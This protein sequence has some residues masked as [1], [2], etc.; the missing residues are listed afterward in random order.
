VTQLDWSRVKELFGAALELPPGERDAWLAHACGD[1]EHLRAELKSLVA[2]YESEQNVTKATQPNA[3]ALDEL[4][5]G[6]RIGPYQIIRRIGI[7]G[8]GAVYLA[9]R[10]D[11]TFRKSVAIKVVQASIGTE[12]ILER[13]R[14]ERQIL[15]TL[16]HPNIAKL[17]DG[18][19]TGEGLPF[20]A[21][22]FIEGV[23]IDDYSAQHRLSVNDRVR[24]FCQVCSAV[25]Y[26]HQNL[27][28][29]RDLK[30][31]NILVTAEGVP[32]LLDFGIAK[33][34]K[35]DVLAD[36]T[37]AESRPLTPAY[38]SPEQVR[39][40]PV[41]TASDVYSLGVI[42]YELLTSH[43]PCRPKTDSPQEAMIAIC[44]QQPDPPSAV[45]G[46]PSDAEV[47]AAV[48]AAAIAGERGTSPE[49]LRRHLKGDLDNITLKALRKEPHRRYA[50]VGQFAD[51]L[52]RYL[53]GLP[54]SA[55]RDTWTYRAGK[56]VRRH[57]LFV[58]AA[59]LVAISLA[60]G[61]L[62]ALSQARIAERERANAQRQFNDVRRLATSFLFEF[63][64]AIR[65]LRGSTPARK[66]LVQRALEYL[67]RLESESHGNL[68]LE[69][70]LASAYIKVGDVQGNPY[71]S[72]LGDNKGAVWSYNQAL[73]I[74]RTLVQ[75]NARDPAAQLDLARSLKSLGQVLPSNGSP[76]EGLSDLR[77]ACE[78]FARLSA[79]DAGNSA[80]EGELANC[81]QVRGDLQGH[82]GLPNM[83]D[84]VSALRSYH[85]ALAIY[86]RQ[87]SANPKNRDARYGE[88]MLRV[89]IGDLA[90]SHGDLK[91]GMSEYHRA[92]DSLGELSAADPANAEALRLVALGY[93]KIG[94]AQEE[95][96]DTRNALRSYERA[97]SINEVLLRSDPG[98]AQ[99]A[100]ALAITL[101][102]SGDL[103]SR[104]GDTASALSNYEKVLNI[105]NQ[106]S[107]EQPGNVL[108]QGRRTEQLL[109][110][111]DI[112]QRRGNKP[113]A[114]QKTAEAQAIT[115]RLAS[116]EDATADDLYA[117]ALTFLDCTPEEMRDP[118]TAVEYA[119]RAVEKS[120]RDPEILELLGRAYYEEGDRPHAIVA[121][122]QALR[123][124]PADGS[125]SAARRRINAQL[126]KFRAAGKQR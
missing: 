95:S 9:V 39:G 90:L 64:G 83:D 63:D 94:A 47:P 82:S 45:I 124:L 92:L 74:S 116:R 4:A 66:L 72:N 75:A 37:R 49:K 32:K 96:G 122:E 28:V 44:E 110:I 68:A 30:P 88:A 26:V 48:T 38:A 85:Q 125:G 14:H 40:E 50:S 11:D 76:T 22:D 81:Y 53:E 104:M 89:K 17:L 31:S 3:A 23:R 41:T 56:F 60:A 27:V 69:S 10:A 105:L 84:A 114:R 70:E 65:N 35:P 93:R 55:H 118:A 15:A 46:S 8:M 120:P 54:V 12:E 123:A 52:R 67:R 1:D 61:I 106:L 2:A 25:Q 119:R 108:V 33:L 126:A 101:R 16:D 112:L 34:L 20:F 113:E 6:K 7:G 57:A 58:A 62:I 98:N 87:A 121:A 86:E 111:A 97:A 5:A 115:R 117:Y 77:T 109:Y 21:M 29:H 100:M 51:D 13:F 71:G 99:F 102:Y 36:L 43:L 78:L 19:I 91:Q 103:L 79:S 107:A 73:R 24:L 59:V 18:G 42:L 80:I